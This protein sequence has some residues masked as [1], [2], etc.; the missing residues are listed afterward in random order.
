MR[1]LGAS[2]AI[3]TIV[4]AVFTVAGYYQ[5]KQS[6]PKKITTSDSKLL[7]SSEQ[8]AVSL[9]LE[10][11]NKRDEN[12]IPSVAILTFEELKALRDIA[13]KISNYNTRDDELSKLTNLAMRN[14]YLEYAI[15][16]AKGISN[17]KKE[18]ESLKNIAL[19]SIQ[20]QQRVIAV[21][22]AESIN[23]YK[24]KNKVLQAILGSTE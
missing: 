20:Q 19:Y 4:A 13:K 5:V 16:I 8:G 14:G 15:S 7:D 21:D 9:D 6:Q 17:Y 1:L 23:N 11:K 10:I 24:I 18:D 3:A 22:A 2:A 12:S